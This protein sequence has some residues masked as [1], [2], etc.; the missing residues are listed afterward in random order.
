MMFGVV[1]ISV[2]VFS[3]VASMTE[4]THHLFEFTDVLCSFGACFLILIGIVLFGF[5]RWFEWRQ[6]SHLPLDSTEVLAELEKVGSLKEL[7][8]GTVAGLRH[9][10]KRAQFFARHKLNG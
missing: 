6:D 9:N 5:R 4:H 1:A 2:F 10:V 8:S 7:S 3:Q